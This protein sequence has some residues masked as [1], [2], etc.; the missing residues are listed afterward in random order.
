MA[1][2]GNWIKGA[3]ANDYPD[4]EYLVAEM[5]AGPAGKGT[6]LFTQ[7]WGIAEQSD[8]KEQAL[9][10]VQALTTEEAQQ[11]AAE[12]F[13]V[14]PSLQ[15]LGEWYAQTYP[16]DA[17]FVAGGDYGQGP[18]TVPGFAPV[19]AEFDTQLQGLATANVE[20]ILQATQTNAEAVVGAAG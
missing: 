20:Q 6:L 19:L 13:G 11:Q 3:V 17:A 10:L 9:A 8:N 7:C 5:P 18:V 4:I 1:V 12:D 14:M 15:S 16:E 2:E